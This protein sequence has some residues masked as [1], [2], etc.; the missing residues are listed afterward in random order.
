M[1]FRQHSTVY[2]IGLFNGDFPAAKDRDD[3]RNDYNTFSNTRNRA[4]HWALRLKLSD[5]LLL[6]Y[7][8][9]LSLVDIAQM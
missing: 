4:S 6:V 5:V 3:E 1:L 8:T 9:T 7:L 2:R